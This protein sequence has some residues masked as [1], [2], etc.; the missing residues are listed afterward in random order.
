MYKSLNFLQ[1]LVQTKNSLFIM[2]CHNSTTALQL[3]FSTS[4]L[5]NDTHSKA[6]KV[7]NFNEARKRLLIPFCFENHLSQI[8]I[9]KGY[10]KYFFCQSFMRCG[11]LVYHLLLPP[12]IC[13]AS[14]NNFFSH[15]CLKFSIDSSNLALLASLSTAINPNFMINL[16]SL[17]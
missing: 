2:L 15:S 3:I 5:H 13:H 1:Y 12:Q 4:N 16:Q 9:L 11:Q 7:S 10:D 8:T 14:Y 6:S 17:L